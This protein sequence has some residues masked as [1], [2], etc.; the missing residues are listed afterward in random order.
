MAPRLSSFS[1]VV[2]VL[3]GRGGAGPHDLR[4]MAA[5]VCT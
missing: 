1:Y 4:R 3:V 5:T 2:L